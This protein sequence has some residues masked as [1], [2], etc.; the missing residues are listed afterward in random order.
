M[1]KTRRGILQKWRMKSGQT[2]LSPN[3]RFA[4]DPFPPA[5]KGPGST[6]RGVSPE[7]MD[8]AL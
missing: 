3:P 4:G 2:I 8:Q 1:G 6:A 5:L 7:A